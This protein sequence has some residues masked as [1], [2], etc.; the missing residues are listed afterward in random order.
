MINTAPRESSMWPE[1]LELTNV[2]KEV[3]TK[4]FNIKNNKRE[5]VYEFKLAMNYHVSENSN[6]RGKQNKDR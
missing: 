4:S 5:Q 3:I 2:I 1:E 6:L